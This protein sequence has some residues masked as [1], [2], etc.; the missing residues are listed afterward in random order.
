M[1]SEFYEL[2]RS[3]RS[4]RRYQDRPVP[5]EALERLLAA[6]VW[7]P[8][9]HNRQP[10]RF[11]VIADP[12]TRRQLAEAMGA[13]LRADLSADNVPAEVIEKDVSRSYSR[14]TRSPALILVALS[15]IDMD[16]YPDE[17]RSRNEFLMA[18]QSTA[19]AVQ[20]LLLAAHV[21]GLGACW[22]CAPLFCP[23]VVSATLTLPADWQ[24]QALV[25]VGYPAED[26]HSTRVEMDTRILWR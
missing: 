8:S 25:T 2:L 7:S 3:R 13:R 24:P 9:A 23:D 22:M 15:L 18:V 12:E 17:K 6:A 14:L 26:K 16:R 20:N 21:E 5:R 4:V 1:T 10:W 19:M 11:M